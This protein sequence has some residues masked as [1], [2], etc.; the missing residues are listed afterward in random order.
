MPQVKDGT[1]REPLHLA[2]VLQMARHTGLY[3]PKGKYPEREFLE[4][5]VLNGRSAN[6]TLAIAGASLAGAA[7]LWALTRNGSRE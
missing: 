4:M 1:D 5:E 7:V 3:G 2:Q 6:A